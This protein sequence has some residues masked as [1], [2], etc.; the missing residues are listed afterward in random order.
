M[1]EVAMMFGNPR[2][3]WLMLVTMVLLT[4]F[5]WWAWRKKQELIRQFVHT[6]LFDQLTFGV[7]P[8]LQL[9]RIFLVAI[10]V[11]L[12]LFAMAR[13]QWGFTW[14]E[15][16]QRGRDIVVAIDTSKSMLATDIAPNRLDRAKLAALDLLKLAKNDRLGLVTFSG[17]AFLQCPLTLDDEAFRQSVQILEPGIIPQGGTAIGEAIDAALSAFKDEEEGGNHKV[18]ILLTDGEDHDE[19]AMTKVDKAAQSGARIF[20]VGVGTANGELLKVQDERGREVFVKDDMGNVVKSRLNEKLLQKIASSAHGFY[21]PL[22][23]AGTMERLY[24]TG[25]APLPT[26][27]MNTTLYKRYKEQ[28][29]WPLSIALLL[30]VVDL[31]VPERKRMKN[32]PSKTKQGAMAGKGAAAALALLLGVLQPGLAHASPS[33]ALRNY[34]AGNY[35]DALKDYK[36]SL[37]KRPEDPRLHYNAG[38][39]AYQ[40]KQYEEASR[41]FNASLSSPDLN[42]QQKAYYNLGNT[43][44][45]MGDTE[46]DPNKKKETWEQSV[47]HFESALKLN[48]NDADASFNRDYVRKKIVELEQ[49]QQQ[50]Q[51]QQGGDNK[52]QKDQQDQKQDNQDQQEQNK[53]QQQ[54]QDQKQQDNKDQQGQ[55]QKQPQDQQGKQ[56][57]QD[58]NKGEQPSSKDQPKPGEGEKEKPSQTA[59]NDKKESQQGGEGKEDE[60]E[61]NEANQQAMSAALGKM[62][63]AQAKQLLDTQK[64]EEKAMIFLPQTGKSPRNAQFKDW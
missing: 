14:E 36:R 48:P 11:A 50:Q 60:Q 17:T 39:A 26:S 10:A 49:K 63:P 22:R 37:E 43:E 18:I 5:L 23:G 8:K 40:A 58:Q 42:L 15:A 44:F 57:S 51:N 28:F 19:Q 45:R 53:E 31:F 52:D 61:S 3:L 9:T 47:K 24:E 21:I 13:P 1:E 33:R 56:E 16:T 7:S 55:D 41:E 29:F 30:L 6:R 64:G 25:L 12:L 2:A 46:I 32:S 34:E 27:E 4:I 54:K 38:A 20:T 35:K 59:A 62:T